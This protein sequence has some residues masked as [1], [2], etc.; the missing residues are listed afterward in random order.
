[1]ENSNWH[2]RLSDTARIVGSEL[3]RLMICTLD[4]LY[5]FTRRGL[6]EDFLAMLTLITVI[7]KTIVIISGNTIL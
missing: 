3:I 5:G 1:M 6:G 2:H 7:T 4:V